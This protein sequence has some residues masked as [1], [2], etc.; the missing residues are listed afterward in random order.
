ML[1]VKAPRLINFLTYVANLGI[2]V[3]VGRRSID[4]PWNLS[5]G[6]CCVIVLNVGDRGET[7][8][9]RRYWRPR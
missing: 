5:S 7:V 9:A 3:V 4:Y 2:C 6:L 1:T 8:R